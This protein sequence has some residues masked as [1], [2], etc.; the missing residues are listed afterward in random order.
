MCGAARLRVPGKS[1]S[2]LQMDTG[3]PLVPPTVGAQPMA[4]LADVLAHAPKPRMAATQAMV[5]PAQWPPAP[6]PA[7]P[8][9]FQTSPRP[10]PPRAVAP[11]LA[12]ARTSALV[13]VAVVL[14]AV[15]IA[16]FALLKLSGRL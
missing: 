10:P 4:D 9:P 13:I 11:A 7:A 3:R 12:P 6:R 15:A 2:T 16:G 14:A 1:A 8:V 5:T